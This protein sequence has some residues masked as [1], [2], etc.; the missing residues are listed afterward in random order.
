MD[1]IIYNRGVVTRDSILIMST[2]AGR[3]DDIMHFANLPVIENINI[4]KQLW[5]RVLYR[6]G[7]GYVPVRTL[8]IG[9]PR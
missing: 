2:I 3:A 9:Y 6:F 7:L 1:A 4:K 8:A 5:S